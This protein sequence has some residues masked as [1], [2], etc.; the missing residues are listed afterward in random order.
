MKE[1]SL[2]RDSNSF[3][4]S[5]SHVCMSVAKLMS[6]IV[7]TDTFFDQDSE[8]CSIEAF[9][10]EQTFG[11]ASDPLTLFACAFAALIHDVDHPGVPNAQLVKE[12]TDIANKYNNRSVAEQW[13]VD[14]AWNLLMEDRFKDFRHHICPTQSELYRFRELVVNCVMATDIMDKDLKQLRNDR[15]G[16]AFDVAASASDDK[17]TS[18]NRK[19][20]IVIEHLIQA[21]DV[22]HTMQHWHV[23]RKWNER[24]F[25][26]MVEA[27]KAGRA[28]KDPA[29][30]W[31]QGEIG[32]FDFYIIPLAKKL[33]SCG[34]FGVSSD[35]YLNYAL[36]NREEWQQ[37]GK[38]V[39][40][41]MVEALA[42]DLK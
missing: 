9:K 33:S 32:F 7:A 41:E 23:F 28:E 42:V 25:R 4:F 15:W 16:R 31:Y 30:F 39:V 29:E 14:V 17:A 21:S 38:Q 34:V 40:A 3:L 37:K 22:A 13:S 11:I 19:A 10:H 20:T 2:S 36:K 18:M 27:Y 5:A 1:T 8:E 24:L 6:R 26:E 12:G 35:E